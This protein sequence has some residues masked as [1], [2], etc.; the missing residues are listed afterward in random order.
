M[1]NMQTELNTAIAYAKTV[2]TMLQAV[3]TP[4]TPRKPIKRQ[5]R[6][7]LVSGVVHGGGGWTL[8]EWR[9]T[10]TEAEAD[11]QKAE[12]QPVYSDSFVGVEVSRTR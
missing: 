3:F 6:A 4:K 11:L 1:R 12:F 5:Y 2:D 8:G 7:F 9:T 10:A